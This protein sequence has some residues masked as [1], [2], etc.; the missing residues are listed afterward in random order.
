M[1]IFRLIF[2]SVWVIS[3][4][5]NS[6]T[7]IPIWAIPSENN[8]LISIPIWIIPSEDNSLISIPNQVI[9]SEDNSLVSI[10]KGIFYNLIFNTN[11]DILF[12]ANS[13]ISI[14]FWVIA[15]EDK[16]S[17]IHSQSVEICNQVP[18]GPLHQKTSIKVWCPF[19]SQSLQFRLDYSAFQCL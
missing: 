12:R 17:G 2:I 11:G 8:S 13:L 18:L 7:S 16:Q 10:Q 15:S 3:S 5:D 1:G 9:P 19:E 4:E 14:P 6:V